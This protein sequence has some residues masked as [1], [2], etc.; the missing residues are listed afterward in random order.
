MPWTAD[1]NISFRWELEILRAEAL[2]FLIIGFLPVTVPDVLVNSLI[3]F[4][5]A[6]QYSCFRTM[7]G[8]NAYA[9]IFCT[10]NMRSCAEQ[11]YLGLVEKDASAMA[12]GLR[13]LEILGTFFSGV[14]VGV[15]TD[16]LLKAHSAWGIAFLLVL[17][18]KILMKYGQNQAA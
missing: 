14:L 16:S 12:R 18:G 17:A 6:M 2:L 5:A 4:C 3:S 15:L 10:G 1:K 7:E 13:Y 9:S 8:E 11:L